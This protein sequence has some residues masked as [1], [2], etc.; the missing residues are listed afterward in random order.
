M[1]NRRFPRIAEVSILFSLVVI[2][3]LYIGYKVQHRNI[4]SGLLITE[5]FI[6]AL[7]AL[8]LLIIKK[9]DV[10][11]VLRL[12]PLRPLQAL[13]IVLMMPF[14]MMAAGLLN[15]PFILLT[16]ILFG[17]TMLQQPPI[18]PGLGGLVISVLI[19]GGSAG[20]C[21]EILFRGTIMRGLERAD[22]RWAIAVSAILFGLMHLDF[23]K[24]AGTALLGVLIAYL[25]IKSDSLY[26]GILAHFMNNTTGVLLSYVYYIIKEPG[27][28]GPGES[29]VK[30]IQLPSLQAF[31]GL[32]HISVIVGVVIIVM[33]LLGLTA[34]LAG[35][36]AGLVAAFVRNSEKER[37]YNP[38]NERMI[39]INEESEIAGAN[40]PMLPGILWIIPGVAMVALT[41]TILAFRLMDVHPPAFEWALRVLQLR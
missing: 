25:V 23:Q 2:A 31:E 34:L 36:V 32:P 40:E 7:P 37:M 18:L 33:I 19:I 24:L 22:I 15:F 39:D 9:Y 41:Y 13:L 11:R 20:I 16:K 30:D 35:A 14:A 29:V 17:K 26:A 27:T 1:E 3:L 21:E 38:G 10:K 5:I 4:Y 28:P 12:N 8:L 6:I